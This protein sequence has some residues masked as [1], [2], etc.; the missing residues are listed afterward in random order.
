[1]NKKEFANNDFFITKLREYSANFQDLS[2]IQTKEYEDF[3]IEYILTNYIGYFIATL[4]G[5]LKSKFTFPYNFSTTDGIRDFCS[6]KLSE[7]INGKK[8]LAHQYDE[9]KGDVKTYFGTVLKNELLYLI[10]KNKK[11]NKVVS[12][13]SLKE[14]ENF[15]D[16]YESIYAEEQKTLDFS[17]FAQKYPLLLDEEAYELKEKLHLF[18]CHSGINFIEMFKENKYIE[19]E[20]D[21]ILIW[22]KFADF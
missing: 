9:A 14:N 11:N 4:K 2:N 10:S 19:K 15:Q 22:Q 16:K 8:I 17:L 20:N 12:T 7:K 1:M 21:R 6:S 13:D 5:F 3:F 18:V